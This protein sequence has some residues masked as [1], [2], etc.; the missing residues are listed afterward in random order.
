MSAL[1]LLRVQT[2]RRLNVECP[3]HHHFIVWLLRYTGVR[4][5]EAQALTVADLDLTPEGEAPTVRG[6][7]TPAATRTIQF[8]PQLLPPGMLADRAA[9]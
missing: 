7:K 4:V 8:V 6:S 5:A 3:R 9:G 1:E 2:L